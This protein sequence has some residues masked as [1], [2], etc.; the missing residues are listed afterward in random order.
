[1]KTIKFTV[2]P[3]REMGSYTGHA[4]ASHGETLAA[5]ALWH[6]NSARAHD[7]LPPLSRMPTGRV[8][9]TPAR[10]WYVQRKDGGSL[11]T[12][13]KFDTRKEARAMLAEYRISDS[14]ADYYLSI[15][16]CKGWE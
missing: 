14:S 10:K 4:S 2:P 6:Y 7:G 8:Y 15:R 11:E 9:H 1:M 5:N 3:T 16:P 13:D 12:V